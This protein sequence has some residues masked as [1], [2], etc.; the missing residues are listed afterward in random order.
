MLYG[1]LSFV[2][3][4]LTVWVIVLSVYRESA[5]KPF[6]TGFVILFTIAILAVLINMIMFLFYAGCLSSAVC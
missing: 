3:L 4:F 6:L 1:I 2:V 5:A